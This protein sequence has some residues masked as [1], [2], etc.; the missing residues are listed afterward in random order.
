VRG[1]FQEQLERLQDWVTDALTSASVPT[2][3]RAAVEASG[4][5]RYLLITGGEVADE[6]RSAASIAGAA[7]DRVQIWTVPG[8][9][10]TEGLATHPIEW[11]KRVI[12][13]LD[14]TLGTG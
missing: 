1:L 14:E 10:H 3:N 5:A 9:G 7:R 6:A 4:D 13:F 2:S 8:A 12:A 11:E